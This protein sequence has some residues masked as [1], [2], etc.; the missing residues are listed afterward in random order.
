MWCKPKVCDYVESCHAAARSI[1]LLTQ[2][3]PKDEA[4]TR[5]VPRVNELLSSTRRPAQRAWTTRR[6]I[7]PND[8]HTQILAVQRM[9]R[10]RAQQAKLHFTVALWRLLTCVLDQPEQALL[11]SPA[12]NSMRP[13]AHQAQTHQRLCMVSFFNLAHR[14]KI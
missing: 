10:R 8:I 7:L 11:N 6:V 13:I 14:P 3:K 1:N 12:E 9:R 5:I 2:L 4:V